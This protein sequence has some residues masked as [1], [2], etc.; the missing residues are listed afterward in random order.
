MS[1]NSPV[2]KAQLQK[3]DEL[4]LTYRRMAKAS[5][6]SETLEQ[7]PGVHDIKKERSTEQL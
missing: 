1:Q 7:P 2:F 3:T 4:M 6:A 5:A